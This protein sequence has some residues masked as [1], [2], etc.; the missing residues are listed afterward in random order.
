MGIGNTCEAHTVLC[1]N[2]CVGRWSPPLFQGI[3]SPPFTRPLSSPTCTFQP[4]A[5]WSNRCGEPS[6]GA[7]QRREERMIIN[8]GSGSIL[9]ASCGAHHP[10][11]T[12]LDMGA[13]EKIRCRKRTNTNTNTVPWSK[14]KAD[15]MGAGPRASSEV[16]QQERRYH[17]PPCLA[18]DRT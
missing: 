6:G 11:D 2:G 8:F 7:E 3:P 18:L 5:K 17:P 13:A 12:Q 15:G 14:T 1:W 16:V 9:V 4:P 10:P